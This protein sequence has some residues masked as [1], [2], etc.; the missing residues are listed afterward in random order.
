MKE[1]KEI[2]ESLKYNINRNEV[3]IVLK[4][5]IWMLNSY[6]NE[7]DKEITEKEAG[8]IDTMIL[9]SLKFLNE[10]EYKVNDKELAAIYLL[11]IIL[12]KYKKTSE[13]RRLINYYYYN[14]NRLKEFDYEKIYQE[15][16]RK[17]TI[18]EDV[19]EKVQIEIA[20]NAINVEY[21]EKIKN[22]DYIKKIKRL[23]IE[24]VESKTVKEIIDELTAKGKGI[25]EKNN[26]YTKAGEKLKEEIFSQEI[27]GGNNLNLKINDVLDKINTTYFIEIKEFQKKILIEFYTRLL[28][29]IIEKKNNKIKTLQE[30]LDK[31]K[32]NILL[33][34][35]VYDD[36]KIKEFR[37]SINRFFNSSANS[38]LNKLYGK[39]TEKYF[40][41]N[42]LHNLFIGNE[43]EV[44]KNI[45]NIFKEL[46]I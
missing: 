41:I 16:I 38:M 43:K 8:Y 10:G 39:D 26:R 37:K 17:K 27:K 1:I 18:I 22:I 36:E 46:N 32:E 28:K 19:S 44:I 5:Y 13:I 21:N 34:L 15:I 20:Y 42:A 31:A 7:T 40:K 14:Q 23:G 4:T 24:N 45:T 29:K 11:L 3:E 9:S 33:V 35:M 25:K 12:L 30:T 2:N 6:K